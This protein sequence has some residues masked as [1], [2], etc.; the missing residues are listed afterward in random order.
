MLWEIYELFAIITHYPTL[1]KCHVFRV[2]FFSNTKAFS[3]SYDWF[4]FLN[5]FFFF[6]FLQNTPTR[7]V[8][9]SKKSP[10]PWIDYAM[11]SNRLNLVYMSSMDKNKSLVLLPQKSVF[12]LRVARSA[13]RVF[14]SFLSLQVTWK[15]WNENVLFH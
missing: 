9:K 15:I 8:L 10:W 2:F 14:S 11:S 1:K 13:L 5:C 6:L 7:I 12:V 4:K 3:V